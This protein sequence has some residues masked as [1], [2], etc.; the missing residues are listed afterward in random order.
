MLDEHGYPT[1]EA[2]ELI[3]NWDANDPIGLMEFVKQCWWMPE[4][5]WHEK[6]EKDDVFDREVI[7]YLVSTGGWSGNEELIGAMRSNHIFWM[8]CWYSSRRG[9]HFVFEVKVK[10][11]AEE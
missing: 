1:E 7:A 9:G 4:W 6:K 2:I 8:M 3:K 10:E 11:L 5:G